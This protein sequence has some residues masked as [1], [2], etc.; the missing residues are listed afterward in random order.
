[1][2]KANPHP[3]NGAIPFIPGTI[4]EDTGALGK[5]TVVSR[6]IPISGAQIPEEGIDDDDKL[7]CRIKLGDIFNDESY[8]AVR[9]FDMANIPQLGWRVT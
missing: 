5:P 2:L 4:P 8:I 7:F 6:R 1:M 9:N 3:H